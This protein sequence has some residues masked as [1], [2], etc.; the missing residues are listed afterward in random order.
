MVTLGIFAV[1]FLLAFFLRFEF[2][3]P[4]PEALFAV[5]S[6]PF[7]L[8]VKLV[9]FYACGTYQ[10]LWAYVGIRDLFRLFRATAFASGGVV[11]V[12]FLFYRDLMAPR[13]VFVLDGMLTFLAVGGVYVL[14]RHLREAGGLPSGGP[15]EPV[16]I[17]GAGD[18]GESLL[19]E[20]QRNSMMNA[21]VVGFI[22]DAPN[23]QGHSLRGVRVLGR[24]DDIR[25]IAYELGVKKAFIA[26]PSA[27]GQAM[28][29]IVSV[30]LHAGLAIRVLPPIGRLANSTRH[31]SQLREV[32][33]EDLLRREPI[34][35]DDQSI[36]A[37]LRD[38]AVLVTGA[39][40]SIGSEL[41]RQIL[42]YRPARL[43]VLDCAETPLHN[44]ILELKLRTQEG[45]LIPVLGDV[46]IRERVDEV[47]RAY[48]PTIVFHA[49][50]L[51]HVPMLESHPGEGV[52]VNVRG[53]QVVAEAARNSAC[54]A[55]VLISTDK[56]VK[57]SSIMGATKRVAEMLVRGL[58]EE[59][60][61]TRYMSVRF[62]NVLGSN[63]SVLPIF[64]DQLARGG[65]LTVTHP[66]MRRYFMTIPE[67][68]ELVLQASV[69]GVG[70]ET[71]VLDMGEPVRIVDLARDLIRL[72]GLIPE[73]DINIEF[74]GIR[75]GE[76]LFEEIRLDS[77]QVEHTSHPQV[78]SLRVQ[79]D[80][81]RAVMSEEM[82]Q[83]L[84][85]TDPQE[86]RLLLRKLVPESQLELPKT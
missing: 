58:D 48:G 60:S 72:S 24:T 6:L 63:G 86:I 32:S 21:R 33:M 8:I 46:T 20:I 54:K 22:D 42:D 81:A 38:K 27:S 9:V 40:G 62:G 70:G 17:V 68:V 47:F 73:V 7:V 59:C 71:F 84:R 15:A 57:P 51:K 11:G 78:L 34:R 29:R 10:I 67:A 43:V 37:F 83:V 1:A 64:R 36:S 23:K 28:R 18:A 69:L 56:A 65:P 26:I 49:A 50:A 52:R 13:S 76:K 35:L 80:D 75:P 12:N 5:G 39:A 31:V 79:S 77:E 2:A 44:L 14:L 25:E 3:I 4:R 61:E 30:L 16:V 41:C 85:A 53:T 74:S 19:R 45:V 82:K 55:F 66:D